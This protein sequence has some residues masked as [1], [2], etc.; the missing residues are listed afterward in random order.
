MTTNPYDRGV[1]GL[2]VLAVLSPAFSLSTTSNTNFVAVHGAGLITFV[3]IGVL[4]L[5]GGLTGRAPVTLLAGAISVLAGVLQF[6]QFGRSKNWL[7]GNGST[8]ALLLG[9]ALGLLVIGLNREA[10]PSV[11]APESGTARLTQP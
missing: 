3:V 2:G 8:A 11:A 4:A 9:L 10:T 5:L 1:L 6:A 7:E